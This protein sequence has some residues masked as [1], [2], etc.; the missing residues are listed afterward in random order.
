MNRVLRLGI[1]LLGCVCVFVTPSIGMAQEIK[2]ESP[3][4]IL[5]D[6]VSG[7]ILYQKDPH[8]KRPPASITKIMTLVLAMEA[9][10]SKRVSLD[11]EV[12]ASENAWDLGGS[13]VYTEPGETFKFS[14][15]LKALV[16]GSANDAAVVVA[17]HV[18]GTEEHFVE[19]MNEKARAL[20]MTDTHFTNCHGLDHENHYTSAYDVALLSRYAV[21]IP[22]V[23]DLTK[24][25]HDTFRNG[26]FEL[27]NPNKLLVYYSGCDGLKTGSTSKAGFCLAATAKRGDSRAIAVVMGAPSSQARFNDATKLLNYAFANFAAV[28]YAKQGTSLLSLPVN[29][30]AKP[31]V[32][33]AP[34]TDVAISVKKGIEKSVT[35]KYELPK[36]VNAPVKRGQKV[37]EAVIYVGE[38]VAKRIDLLALEEV[39]AN[40]I[41]GFFAKALRRLLTW[42]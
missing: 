39:K 13:E 4:A 12:A 32:E 8:S 27:Y 23:L 35:V 28:V 19:M 38:Q 14:D 9:V 31:S 1:A 24:I 37:G 29:K 21:T 7:E 20:G 17:E 3:S 2:I 6:A 25:Y 30:G 42:Q 22:G 33:I 26:K 16:I 15:W 36:L 11:D 40:T 10:N 5:M 18:G 34:A 41:P